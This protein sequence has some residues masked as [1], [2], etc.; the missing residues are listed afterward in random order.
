MP[1]CNKRIYHRAQAVDACECVV[2]AVESLVSSSSSYLLLVQFQQ[3]RHIRVVAVLVVIILP[4]RHHIGTAHHTQHMIGIIIILLDQLHL[5]LQLIGIKIHIIGHF[6][7]PH[8][9][10]LINQQ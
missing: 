10:Y 2:Y 6:Q 4:L 8:Q 3:H 7:H 1:L 9:R 5:V